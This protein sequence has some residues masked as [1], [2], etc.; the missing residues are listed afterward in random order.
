MGIKNIALM[1]LFSLVISSAQA[2][3]LYE[4]F[5]GYGR[6]RVFLNEVANQSGQDNLKSG[7]FRAVF[8]K[9]LASRKKIKFVYV[10]KEE[11]ADVIVNAVI[12]NYDFKKKAFPPFYNIYT[13]VPDLIMPSGSVT[14]TVD[15]RVNKVASLKIPLFFNNFKTA[16][17]I[18]DSKLTDEMNIYNAMWENI[19]R[20]IY[21][22][23][24]KQ[25]TIWGR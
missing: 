13:L 4:D 5:Q 20:F 1:I 8:K 6:I 9:V 14:I 12:K 7:M 16:F 24:Y 22:A 18:R 17:R 11:N 25:N 15:Y 21:R 2:E 23:F 3:N 10:D 19:N